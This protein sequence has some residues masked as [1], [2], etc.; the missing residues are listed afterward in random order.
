MLFS[1]SHCVV[2]KCVCVCV[3]TCSSSEEECSPPSHKDKRSSGMKRSHKRLQVANAKRK[4]RALLERQ[5]TLEVSE[6]WQQVLTYRVLQ[7]VASYS[8]TKK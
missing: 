1:P 7:T 3:R 5:V 8:K 2:V 6:V 4:R